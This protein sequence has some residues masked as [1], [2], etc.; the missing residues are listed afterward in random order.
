MKYPEL[1]NLLPRSGVRALRRGYFI[2][3]AI[4]TV[5]LAIIALIIHGALLLPSYLYAH[6][7]VAREQGELDRISSSNSSAQE[8]DIQTHIASVKSDIEYLGRL[9]TLPTASGAFRA[10]LQVPHPGIKIAGFTFTAPSGTA[11]TAQMTVTGTAATRDQL[12]AYVQALGQLPY[13]S[14]ADLPISAYAKDNAIPFTITLSGSLT[15]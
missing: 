14:N 5:A 8:R 3:L 6:Q 10:V 11:H 7:E 1:T 12:R 2:K 13:V 4:V 9:G 15:P